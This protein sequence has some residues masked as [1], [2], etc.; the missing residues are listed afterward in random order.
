MGEIGRETEYVNDLESVR[1]VGTGITRCLP[2]GPQSCRTVGSGFGHEES[3]R[4]CVVPSR[5]L[6]VPWTD[7]RSREELSTTVEP[8]EWN[9][10]T[11][12][13]RRRQFSHT[14]KGKGALPGHPYQGEV[15][16]TFVTNRAGHDPL[17]SEKL[18]E[19]RTGDETRPPSAFSA[20]LLV[21]LFDGC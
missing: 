14:R 6:T 2:R 10:G 11:R 4:R 13:Q 15:P 3:H 8:G 19:E 12:R 17:L 21:L 16:R 20:R 9:G 5:S 7:L 18:G 1:C